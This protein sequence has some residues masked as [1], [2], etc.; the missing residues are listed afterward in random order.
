MESAR[1]TEYPPRLRLDEL[2]EE[3]QVRIDGVRGTQDR[4]HS[5]LE[6]V[7]TVGRELDLSHVLRR[8]VEAAVVLVD[9][10][11]GA[12]G[13][14]GEDQRLAEFLPVGVDKERAEAIGRLPTGHGLL[15]ELIRHP[16]PL[17]LG[18]LSEHPASYGFPPNHPP[19]RSFLGVPIRVRDEVFGNL[20]LTEKRGGEEFDGEDET[21]LSTLAVAAGVA[22]ENARLYEEARHRQR[23]LEANAE[24][25]HSLLSGVDET[26]VLELIVEHARRILS[27]DLGVLM[28]PVADTDELQVALASGTDAEAHR[29]LVLPRRG[30][31]GGAA[32]TASEPVTST[33][34]Q[35]DPRIT[36]G[37]QRWEGLGPA[38]A[39]PMRT[40]DGVGGVL[41]LARVA[42]SHAFTQVETD[43]LLGFA[44]Q[45][46][47][48]MKLAERRRDA[49]QLA[50]LE[51]RDRIARD[52]H[53]LAIQRLFAAGMTLQ[54]TLRFVQ[55]PEGSERLLRVVD[56]LDDTI[57]I[58]RS[59]IFGLRS[60]EAGP[61][62]QGLRVRT[63]KTIEEAVSALGFTPSLR[64]EGLVDTD[65]PCSVA[66]DMV[67]V[68]AEAMS[69]I[70]RHARADAAE[71]SLV[72]ASGQLTLTVTDNGVG[73][74]EGGHRSG[75]R[76]LA[77]RAE[78]LGG[79]LELGEP[80]GGG[81]RLAWAVPLP[82]R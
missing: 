44:G 20:Y 58:I 69:N 70:A 3:L 12:L 32:F 36:V 72:V 19:M 41:S 52:L 63:A 31:F 60:H 6:A 7:L 61:A 21:V 22:I 80:P 66:D 74:P 29:G 14:I 34:V 10:E 82:E 53:D 30:T 4:V 17:R 65:V 23:W 42:D 73:I 8:I 18:E 43:T 59:T 9:A 11:Y 1:S 38:V 46:A 5:L 26:R 49:E 68:L 13:V 33:D 50:L 55:H 64:T 51:D 57:K 78:K 77:E 54:S 79:E 76:N 15:G 39:V 24:V 81:T 2:L 67:A 45:A 27:A 71:I 16:K 56:D 62:V 37:P 75:L 48:A 40:H 28:L 25:T 47:I 35:N